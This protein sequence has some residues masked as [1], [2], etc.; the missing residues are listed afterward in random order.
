MPLPS[1]VHG[2][3]DQSLIGESLATYFSKICQQFADRPALIVRHQNIRWS[4]AELFELAA[5][6]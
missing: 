4:Y 1:Y 6:D 5:A 3:S 2:A